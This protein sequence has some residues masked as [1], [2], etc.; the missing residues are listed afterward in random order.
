MLR[1]DLRVL[2]LGGVLGRMLVAQAVGGELAGTTAGKSPDL[3]WSTLRAGSR[4]CCGGPAES[5]GELRAHL[6]ASGD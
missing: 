1:Q 2:I 4:A 5:M 6:A 3:L